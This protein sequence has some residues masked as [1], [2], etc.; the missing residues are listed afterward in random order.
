MDAIL[1]ADHLPEPGFQTCTELGL[2]PR[3]V[4]ATILCGGTSNSSWDFVIKLPTR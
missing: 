1:N 2:H 3:E 4:G